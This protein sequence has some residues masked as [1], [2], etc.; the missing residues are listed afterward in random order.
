[1]LGV[2][3][4]LGG[5][6]TSKLPQQLLA[7]LKRNKARI[8]DLFRALDVNRDG[9]ITQQEFAMGMAAL[10]LP[11]SEKD[12]DYLFDVLDVSDDNQA[13]YEE[14]KVLLSMKDLADAD[15][16]GMAKIRDTKLR[17]K[18]RRTADIDS[19]EMYEMLYAFEQRHGLVEAGDGPPMS[20]AAVR[21]SKED[22]KRRERLARRAEEAE[23]N[24]KRRDGQMTSMDTIWR[25]PVPVR[26]DTAPA[27]MARA[28]AAQARQEALYEM[29]YQKHREEAEHHERLVQ[30]ARADA[31]REH[32]TRVAVRRD[33]L[34]A[35]LHERQATSKLSAVERSEPFWK[36]RE[37]QK[38]AENY[39]LL[40]RHAALDL[41]R[42]AVVF[43]PQ[44][45][46]SPSLTPDRYAA[47]FE[48]ARS[49]VLAL[50][51]YGGRPR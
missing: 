38:S 18:D 2:G 19:A 3:D 11:L 14:L 21:E 50:G 37:A 13:T 27:R 42:N 20:S 44:E 8:L 36:R 35:V 31:I 9:I 5:V 12:V 48:D 40:Q 47:D 25:R 29:W 34:R 1:M 39:K 30:A 4:D 24:R 22:E 46:S 43:L 28:Q 23:S 41:E 15:H 32:Q 26:P 7:T 49:Q 10:G 45:L 51:D 6:A 16:Y 33:K 17:K